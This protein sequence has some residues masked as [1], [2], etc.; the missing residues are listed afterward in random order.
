MKHMHTHHS[1]SVC[2]ER[3]IIFIAR[4]GKGGGGGGEKFVGDHA[5][6]QGERRVISCRQQSLKWVGAG[7]DG[8][9]TGDNNQ[10]LG[11]CVLS[12]LVVI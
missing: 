2:F 6:F 11:S 12:L 9:I 5:V 10:S 7:G 4:G 1:L 8:T 3:M